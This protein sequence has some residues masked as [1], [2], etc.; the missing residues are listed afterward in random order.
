MAIIG[1]AGAIS[2]EIIRNKYIISLATLVIFFVIATITWLSNREIEKSIS[3]LQKSEAELKEDALV[4]T[5]GVVS[6]SDHIHTQTTFQRPGNGH[7][8]KDEF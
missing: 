1:F 2:M 7:L 3:K 8:S 4:S 6:E 5:K